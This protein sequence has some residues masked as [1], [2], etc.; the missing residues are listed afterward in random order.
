MRVYIIRILFVKCMIKSVIFVIPKTNLC[1]SYYLFTFRATTLSNI[2][3]GTLSF[4]NYSFITTLPLYLYKD[5]ERELQLR[6]HSKNLLKK[7]NNWGQVRVPF[8]I[9]QKKRVPFNDTIGSI[10]TA[11]SLLLATLFWSIYKLT[12]LIGCGSSKRT[13]FYHNSRQYIVFNSSSKKERQD[14]DKNLSTRVMKT[15]IY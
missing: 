2:Y 8:H 4:S 12:N 5:Y 6:H 14:Q 11:K 13:S 1:I 9:K 15:S 3:K 7:K 10:L